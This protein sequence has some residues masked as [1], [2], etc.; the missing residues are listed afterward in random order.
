MVA[1]MQ[2]FPRKHAA[3]QSTIIGLTFAMSRLG[4]GC[5]VQRWIPPAAPHHVLL[6]KFLM[7]NGAPSSNVF[8]TSVWLGNSHQ[9]RTSKLSH[10]RLKATSNIRFPHK[11][12]V[13][14]LSQRRLKAIAKMTRSF[15]RCAFGTRKTKRIVTH[16]W[17]QPTFMLTQSCV[18][19]FCFFPQHSF[20]P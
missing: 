14:K 4:H 18:L 2:R 19:A 8:K 15:V 9:N 6:I 13:S 17:C 7:P 11:S 5:P 12:A 1:Q 10:M 16:T 20:P 3:R